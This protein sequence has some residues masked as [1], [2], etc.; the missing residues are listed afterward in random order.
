MNKSPYLWVSAV[1]FIIVVLGNVA[2]AQETYSQKYDSG[3]DIRYQQNASPRTYVKIRIYGNF[4]VN[5]RYADLAH[6]TEHM[7]PIIKVPVDIKKQVPI[8]DEAAHFVY[9]PVA[10]RGLISRTKVY[11][12]IG[13]SSNL[14]S[15]P[16]HIQTIVEEFNQSEL[17]KKLSM[18]YGEVSLKLT[19]SVL[20]VS[21]E[22]YSSLM[23]QDVQLVCAWIKQAILRQS[24]STPLMQTKMSVTAFLNTSKPVLVVGEIDA[25]SAKKLQVIIQEYFPIV[26][27]QPEKNISHLNKISLRKEITCPSNKMAVIYP[28]DDTK[29]FSEYGASLLFD[30]AFASPLHRAIRF[31]GTQN[32]WFSTEL[33]GGL[34]T[35]MRIIF[36]FDKEFDSKNAINILKDTITLTMPREKMLNSF[37]QQK[38]NLLEDLM[39]DKQYYRNVV[40]YYD[41]AMK[42]DAS[43][44]KTF[45]QT[46]NYIRQISFEDFYN[47]IHQILNLETSTPL[48]CLNGEIQ[49]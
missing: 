10:H 11:F 1:I 9:E 41:N 18:Q 38:N 47:E 32:Y 21:I 43:L 48:L 3:L 34:E 27:E 7:P 17:Q 6:L 28:G 12:R 4:L 20:R 15:T 44:F 30:V 35:K 19:N 22:D 23:E 26:S 14:E 16:K 2:F 25:I 24:S 29:I 5:N 39:S 49:N 42:Y 40:I 46:T 33:A 8:V 13:F 31:G 36:V 37:N 45:D